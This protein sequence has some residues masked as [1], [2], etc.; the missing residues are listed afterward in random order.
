[1]MQSTKTAYNPLVRQIA[2]QLNELYV[3]RFL[4][5]T[6]LNNI[7]TLTKNRNALIGLLDYL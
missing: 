1:M 3:E 6:Q 4:N 2:N 5:E 7:L